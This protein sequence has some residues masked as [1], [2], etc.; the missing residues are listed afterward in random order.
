MSVPSVSGNMFKFRSNPVKG[1]VDGLA[2]L[3]K[4]L[5]SI[6]S[7]VVGEVLEEQ[8]SQMVETSESWPAELRQFGVWNDRGNIMVGARGV[9][10]AE[11][12]KYE[13]GRLGVS[14]NPVVRRHTV[15]AEQEIQR[16][17]SSRLTSAL[18][19]GGR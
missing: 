18:L 17:L 4:N 6:V 10:P 13:Y 7:G 8:A 3:R 9:N 11:A 12:A 1:Y 14:P 5:D 2:A 15:M 16:K 19:R